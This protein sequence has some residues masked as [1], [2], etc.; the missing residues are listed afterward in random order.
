VIENNI[1]AVNATRNFNLMCVVL[2]SSSLDRDFP[3]NFMNG[4]PAFLRYRSS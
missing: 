4:V 2:L 1:L 3:F